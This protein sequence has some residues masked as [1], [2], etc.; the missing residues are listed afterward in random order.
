MRRWAPRGY[1]DGA[2][3]LVHYRHEGAR[4]AAHGAIVLLHQ[5]PMTS[6]QYDRVLDPLAR[7]GFHAIAI[8]MPGFGM[9]DPVEGVPRV[10]DWASCVP[11]VLEALGHDRAVVLGH[12][13]GAL[14][15]TE[16]AL[17]FPEYVRAVIFNGP[18]PVSEEE[19]QNFFENGYRRELAITAQS[20]GGQ[21]LAVHAARTRLAAGTVAPERISEYV[22]MAF[23]G[24]GDYWHGHHAAFQYD[25]GPRLAQIACPALVLTNTGD[26]IYGHALKV[27][28][29]RPDF[30]FTALEGGGIDIVDQ[31]GEDWAEAVLAFTA[32][33]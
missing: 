23:Q 26:Q 22:I 25:Q 27:R 7:R 5:A 11:P 13:T 10:E 29:L 20:D 3:G 4:D 21:F 17:Q 1:A 24:Q 12:H 28:A 32:S 8:D 9:S 15:A 19:R 30:A 31:H 6:A 33:L 16:V 2:H 14:V 18:M